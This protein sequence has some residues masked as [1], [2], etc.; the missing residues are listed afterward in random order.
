MVSEHVFFPGKETRKRVAI[1]D[2]GINPDTIDKKYLCKGPHFDLTDTDMR[3]RRWHGTHMYAIITRNINPKTQCVL[4][5]KY[6]DIKPPVSMEQVFAPFDVLLTQN[7]SYINYSSSGRVYFKKEETAIKAL[8]K[9]KVHVVVAAGNDD[10]NLEYCTAYPACY[11][12]DSNYFHVIGNGLDSKFKFNHT[13]YNGPIT[14]YING[15]NVCVTVNKYPM[16]MSGTSQAT[17][18][19]TSE[20]IKHE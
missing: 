6:I 8:L 12:F 1:I 7:V 5:V 11:K 4:I 14:T 3:D 15:N 19:F 17:A 13:N 20:L 10:I 2:T 18:K 9:K 16:C